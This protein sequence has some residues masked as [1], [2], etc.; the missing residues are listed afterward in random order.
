M[1]T[2]KLRRSSAAPIV[3]SF[4]FVVGV[5][6][7]VCI[8]FVQYKQSKVVET[9]ISKVVLIQ[10]ALIV[11]FACSA[12]AAYEPGEDCKN[13]LNSMGLAGRTYA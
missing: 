11:H 12:A 1:F 10:T 8:G 4:I 9:N 3:L 13:I 7:S 2:W 5:A 6:I